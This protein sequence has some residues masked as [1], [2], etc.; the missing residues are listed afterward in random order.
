M[1]YEYWDDKRIESIIANLAGKDTVTL[2]DLTTFRIS[3]ESIILYEACIHQVDKIGD[4]LCVLTYGIDAHDCY[5]SSITII[6][7]LHKTKVCCSDKIIIQEEV[8]FPFEPLR[9]MHDGKKD[10]LN[11]REFLLNHSDIELGYWGIWYSLESDV[12]FDFNEKMF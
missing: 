9:S 1:E 8:G 4:E 11:K 5:Y 3:S 12:V 10:F 2:S 6:D 7:Y